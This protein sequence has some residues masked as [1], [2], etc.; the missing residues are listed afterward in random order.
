MKSYILLLFITITRVFSSGGY[1]QNVSLNF[2]NI[3][4]EKVLRE[5]EVKS[6]YSFFYSNNLIDNSQKVS[7]NVSDEKLERTLQLLFHPTNIDF[8]FVKNQIVLFPR[9]NEDIK[10]EIE[11]LIPEND[12]VINNEEANNYVETLTKIIMQD[13]ITGKITDAKGFPLPGATVIVKGTN[14][15]VQ[16]DFDGIFSINAEPGDILVISYIGFET[17]E[18]TAVK[19]GVNV[20]LLE[21]VNQL[22]EVI[23]TGYGVQRKSRVTG[24]AT[25]L[26]LKAITAVPRAAVQE[27]IQGN[28]AGVQ[29][30]SSSGQPGSTPN[31]RIRG[32][33][34]F[35]SAFPLYVIDGFQTTDAGVVASL[36]PNDIEAISVLK[37]AASTSIYGT[38]GA[39][40]VIVIQTKSGRDGKTKVSYSTQ[41]G[42][43]S[44]TVADRFKAL[45]TPELQEL[46]VEGVQNAGI[47]NNDADALDFLISNGFNPDVNTDWFDLITRDGLYQQHDLSVTGGSEKTRFFISG[48]Y[49]NQ[50]GVILASG[51]ERMNSR[52]KLDHYFTDRLKTGA[53]ISY[54]KSISNVR[55][56]GGAFANPVRSIYRIRPDISPF[57]E[58]GTFNFGF[59]STHN[60]LAQAEAETRR[61]ITHRILAGANLSYEILEG[62]TYE[63]LI[64]MNQTFRDNFIRL[65]AG[66][67]D[68][69]PTGRGEQDSDFLFSWLFRNLL[70]YNKTWNDHNISAF[71]GYELQKVRNKFSDLTVE[72]IPDGFED[73]N[74][75]SLP[76]VASTNKAQ[77]GLNSVFLNAEY[78]YADKYLI[79]GS[80]RRDGS[81]SFGEN[82]RFANFWSV[83]IGWNLA[84]ENFMSDIDFINVLKFRASYGANG[85][86]PVSGIFNLFSVNDYDGSPGLIFSDVGN[87][88]IK[89]EVNKPLNVGIDYSVF[90]GRIQGS[91]DWYKRETTDLLRNR[92]ISASNGDTSIAENIG[93]MENTGVELDITTRNF[94]AVDNG[95]SWTTNFNVTINRNKVT[96]LSGNDEPIIGTTSIIA[97][98]EDFETFYLPVY[99]GVD[100]ANG[101]ALWY[102]DG[103]R[104]EVTA[105]YDN[106]NQAIIGRATPDFY[107]GLRNT[108]SYKGISLDFQLYTAW[109]G[110]VYDTW[111]RFTNSDGSRRLS[112]TGNVS[113]GTYERRWQRPG[114]IT[115]VPAF[116]YGNTQT[117]SSSQRSSRFIYDGSYIRLRE[118]SLTYQLPSSAI[119]LIGLSTA[120]VYVK[121]NNLYTFLRDDRLERD[122]EA[123]SDGRLNQ[124]IPIS[125]AL[126]LGLDITF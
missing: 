118:V 115:D 126:F 117:G 109:G 89:W 18:V 22:N 88:N 58:D 107:A 44:A 113:R 11:E 97:V 17:V 31:V 33:G 63:S 28:V 35:D 119:S 56:D 116:V 125:R 92:P 104:T 6:D 12:S 121:G 100:P 76:T 75:G 66:F 73:L 90:N 96:R 32:V 84:N 30:T 51:F 108:I 40:G 102:T 72:N 86:D 7:I 69:R 94:V 106:A 15:G 74:N 79:S 41:S 38:R 52:L 26:D 47:R 13:P 9:D 16:T 83:G 70:K 71:G 20:T 34:S 82:N 99:A 124:E 29:V 1:A 110:L 65:P 62:L 95:F 37:D 3:A 23:V 93:S 91:F 49:F 98:G 19:S 78:S 8:T 2:E 45:S 85:N 10:K 111:N 64:N 53:Y 68:G 48:G 122:P 27:S 54:N 123:G 39:N 24:S 103:T 50:E 4:L 61:N 55:P 120:R 112:S 60:P 114:D 21:S 67:G 5:I 59:N 43:S 81:S 87:P 57:N 14:T 36:N 77:S 105:D 80:V 46:L 101:N 42:F 25:N